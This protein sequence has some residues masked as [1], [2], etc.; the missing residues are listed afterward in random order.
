VV[1][2]L[3]RAPAERA[4]LARILRAEVGALSRQEEDSA[5]ESPISYG[6][7]DA[8]Y[9]DWLGSVLIGTDMDDELRVLELAN[10]ALLELRVLD[11]ELTSAVDEAYD[12]LARGWKTFAA[13]ASRAR[14]LGRV[15]RLQADSAM[16]YESVKNAHKLFGDDYLARLHGRA[17]QRFRLADWDASIGRKLSVLASVYEQL[18]D[19]A[20]Q[21]RSE[22]LEWIIILLI[23]A[24]MVVY[25]S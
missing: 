13:F 2:H 21:R 15:A 24:D 3:R 18:S 6:P 25:L 10:V 11:A 4:P 16:L 17:I 20:S 23:A 22:A 8:C 5:L 7:S 14:E 1:F 12:A 19:R 9:V